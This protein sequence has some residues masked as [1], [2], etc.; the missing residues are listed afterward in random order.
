[1]TDKQATP[2][3][4]MVQHARLLRERFLADAQRPG[5]HFVVPEDLGLPG[6]PNG[7]FFANGRYHL[8]YLYHRRE[9]GFCWGHVSSAD[10]IHWRHHPDA[11]GP[12][13]GDAGCFSG[14][15]FVDEDGTAY[16]SY[17][18]LWDK[19]GI[20][21]AQSSDPYYERWQKLPEPAIPATSFG[22]LET[23]DAAGQSL[24]LACA[25]P[26]NIWKKDGLYYLQ[27]GNLPVLNAYGRQPDQP[28]HQ[29]M[30]GDWVD[31]FRSA[32]LQHWEYVH[33]FYEHDQSDRWTDG[34]ED[35]MCPS[36][37]P[38]PSSPDG[39]APSGKYLQLFIA[40]NK[41]C[42]YY[43]G[44]Y[45]RAQDRFVP[46]THGRMSWVDNTFF[47]PE[48]LVDGQGRQIMWAWLLDNA[49]DEPSEIERGWSG[50]YGLPRL[51]WLGADGA[52]RQRV[53]PE[54]QRLRFNETKWAGLILPAGATQELPG[55]NGLACELEIEMIA[56]GGGQAGLMVRAS[57]AGEEQTRLFYDTDAGA[58]VFDARRSSAAGAGRPVV[59]KAPFTLGAGEKLCL[60]VF[61]DKS[62][63]EIFANDLQAIT[64]RVFPARPESV[65]IYLFSQG[66]DTTFEQVSAWEMMP[67]NPY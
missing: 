4:V 9:V 63:I 5:Y 42:Q 8:M 38:L 17:W 56:P 7:A 39:G 12:G 51:L 58:L 29:Q 3:A 27:T 44:A 43:I 46:E 26:S 48:A 35:D 65:G 62:V 45:D 15:A 31:L 30:R 10:L 52:L 21:I 36:F 6:D 19:Q 16:L 2:T 55:L 59:E 53:P 54:F 13:D 57:A 50:V 37:L 64:R 67:S 40:H 28:L 24:I 34:T 25:D 11:L 41:G 20:G 23:T 61:I 49:G 60:R 33:R 66:G 18:R 22:I 47:A 32:D 1:M 14:G